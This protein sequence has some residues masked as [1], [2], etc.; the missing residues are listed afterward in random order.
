VARV[1]AA[2][3]WL[4]RWSRRRWRRCAARP[5]TRGILPRP[6]VVIHL[7]PGD[8]V[9]R[10]VPFAVWCSEGQGVPAQVW[11]DPPH[12]GKGVN[13]QPHIGNG[14]LV[15]GT[16]PRRPTRLQRVRAHRVCSMMARR[17]RHDDDRARSR[18]RCGRRGR[19]RW[20][21]GWAAVD[22]IVG[23]AG[24]VGIARGAVVCA[25]GGVLPL[26][27]PVAA[28]AVS[29]AARCWSWRRG[30]SGVQCRAA[31]AGVAGGAVVIIVP[32][33]AGGQDSRLRHALAGRW[34]RCALTVPASRATQIA[35]V[36]VAWCGRRALR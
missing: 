2:R 24:P 27:V 25:C 33:R 32:A 7:P 4:G 15:R 14:V 8:C 28:G 18:G 26:A 3:C 34:V 21:R 9:R 20:R 35:R 1:A 6:P 12:I 30:P 10:Q 29:T 5:Y 36:T 31:V 17:A 23:G 22:G 11:P 19:R 16:P 13:V